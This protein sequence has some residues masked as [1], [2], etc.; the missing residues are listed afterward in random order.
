VAD[1]SWH[2]DAY[3]ELR[4]GPPWVMQEMTGSEP[5]RFAPRAAGRHGRSWNGGYSSVTSMKA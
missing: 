3:P 2:T 1:S 5:T 4:P